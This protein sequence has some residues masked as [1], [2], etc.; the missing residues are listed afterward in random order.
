M[1][2]ELAKAMFNYD[3]VSGRLFWKFS[4]GMFSEGDEV[5]VKT[6]SSRC[7]T[8]YLQVTLFKRTYKVHRLIWLILHGQFPCGYIDHIDGNGL[9][10]AVSNL[11]EATPSQN[12]MNQR[13]RCDSSSGVKG[14]SF[15]KCRNKWYAYINANGKRTMLGRFDNKSEAVNARQRAEMRHHGEFAAQ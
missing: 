13:T 6:S 8:Q 15:D 12:M 1:N 5:G 14:V 2:A 3:K 7:H 4:S 9:N 11:R 10:N